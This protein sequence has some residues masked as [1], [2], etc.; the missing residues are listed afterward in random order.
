M[1]PEIF[2][3]GGYSYKADSN[4]KKF[5]RKYFYKK[6]EKKIEKLTSQEISTSITKYSEYLQIQF[7]GILSP[8]KGERVSDFSFFGNS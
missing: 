3:G 7:K 8:K 4:R 5:E 6:L 1:A 2:E